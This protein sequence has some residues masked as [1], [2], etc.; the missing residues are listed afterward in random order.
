MSDR[1]PLFP[2]PCT[3]EELN[4]LGASAL[5]FV[6]DSVQTLFV[7]TALALECPNKISALHR[8]AAA[9]INATSQSEAAKKIIPLLSE[10]EDAV[11]RRC[12]NSKTNT[13]AKNATLIDYKI[14]SG[15]EGLIGYLY[16]LGRHE[17]L[18]ELLRL[19]YNNADKG[20]C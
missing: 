14:A 5:S 19:A 11:F 16:M 18:A 2:E 9:V 10:E 17:R 6:G 7:R 12:R 3:K 1:L 15:L 8:Q 4:Q 13:H 20:N